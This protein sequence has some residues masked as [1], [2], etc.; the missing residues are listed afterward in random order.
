MS[1]WV[2]T[3]DRALVYEGDDGEGRFCPAHGTPLTEE[4]EQAP[5]PTPPPEPPAERP[6]ERPAEPVA[7][8]AA[9]RPAGP[10]AERPAERLDEPAEVEPRACLYCD[11]PVPHASNT[12]CLTCHRPLDG[13]A[14]L[15]LRFAGGETVEVERDGTVLLGRALASPAEKALR[16]SGRVSREHATAGVDGEGRAWVRDERSLNGTFVNGEEVTPG[17]PRP[18]RDGDKVRLGDRETVAVRLAPPS[19]PDG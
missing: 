12:R 19:A 3:F 18:L 2:C 16:D 10:A 7:E 5:E 13:P 11:T 1:R 14:V 6:A 8:P 17:V 4:S 9:E 15:V